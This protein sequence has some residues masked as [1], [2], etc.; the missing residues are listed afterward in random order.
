MSLPLSGY[1]RV[2]KVGDREG[3]GF[4]S[5]DVQERAIREWGKRSGVEVV[6]EP[7]ELNASGGTMDR[8]IFNE[9]M[10]KVRGGRSGGIVV[11]KTDRFAR[12]LL[13]AISTMA[14]LG[15]HDAVLASATEPE[16]DYTTPSGKAFMQ[17]M[18]VFSE[19][20]RSTLKESWATAARH[21]IERGVHIAPHVPLGY[22]RGEDRRLVPND[23]APIVVEIF[24][25]R[26]RGDTWGSIAS[27]LNSAA[28]R[29]NGTD[30]TG[31]TVQRLCEKR[32]YL[33]EASRYVDQDV[34][35]RGPIV[36]REAHPALVTEAQ[37]RD[38]QMTPRTAPNGNGKPL[39]LLSGLI[40]C[41]GCRYCMSIGRAPN[42]D[43]M[44]RCRSKHAS[45]KCPKPSSVLTERIEAHVEQLV[46]DQL[47]GY[48]KMVPDST[49]RERA[50]VAL[51]DA[52]GDLDVF[53]L[54]RT[55]RRKVGDADWHEWLDAYLNA[56]REAEADL[57]KID[58][59]AGVATEGLTR[60]HYLDLPVD[61]R[62]EV[63]AGFVDCVFVRRSYG[64]GRSAEPIAD[65]VRVLWRGQ[66]PVDL[67]RR[68]VVNEIV[69]F[70][71]GE[72]DVESGV[73]A[74]QDTA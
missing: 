1:V 30:W 16:L 33:G 48:L 21:A 8:P 49:E 20:V 29:P 56:V 68:R 36:N 71:F 46:L 26:G 27:W 18:F 45:G 11:Y 32:V 39:P 6:M 67:P 61:D 51:D 25:R 5:P 58:L 9:I 23:Q 15:A 37:F 3:E 74:A 24:N 69:S 50:V 22:D 65:R 2:S 19:F 44:Y 47:D 28:P 63:L 40:R 52:R 14:E 62:R 12:S 35:G 59:R 60:D 54:D 34:D 4:I 17:Q 53:K 55:V 64:R 43:R 10:D 7:A 13:G 66:A 72:D 31:G 73:T 42:K 70:D 57:E 38:A 41:A